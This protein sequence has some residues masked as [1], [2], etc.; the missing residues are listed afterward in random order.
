MARSS[1]PETKPF[2]IL[3][4][5]IPSV[6]LSG[7]RQSDGQIL[8]MGAKFSDNANRSHNVLACGQTRFRVKPSEITVLDGTSF[9]PIMA[10]AA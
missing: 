3:D 9:G 7:Y 8:L 10:L 4:Q 2:E 6:E 5:E 1:C